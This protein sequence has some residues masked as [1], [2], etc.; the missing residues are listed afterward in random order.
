[1][2]QESTVRVPWWSLSLFAGF[3]L[4]GAEAVLYPILDRLDREPPSLWDGWAVIL[5]LMPLIG[6]LLVVGT[7]LVLT[8][9]TLVGHRRKP[10]A[11]A[12]CLALVI[13]PCLYVSGQWLRS[14]YGFDPP[15]S[16]FYSGLAME[17]VALSTLPGLLV[18]LA[19]SAAARWRQG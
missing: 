12:V 11:W 1:M 17:L 16:L 4:I 8:I 6:F 3:L 18:W 14:L 15:Y 7:L 10:R 19:A 5:M 2:S 9:T 13:A